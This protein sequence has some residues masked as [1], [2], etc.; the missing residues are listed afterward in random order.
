MLVNAAA[1]TRT[2]GISTQDVTAIDDWIEQ[3]VAGWTTGE[4]TVF[5]ARLCIAE[6]AANA[7]E[8]GGSTP[9]DHIIVTLRDGGDGV[10][11]EF[12]DSLKPFDPVTNADG[13]KPQPTEVAG[14]GLMLVRNYARELSYRNDGTYNRVQFTIG[15]D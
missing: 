9:D 7:L 15:S 5:K 14:R 12:M 4:R 3:V 13:A 8:H 11:I 10:E 2:F 6:L 1:E